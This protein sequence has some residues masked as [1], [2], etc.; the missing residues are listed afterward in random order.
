MLERQAQVALALQHVQARPR[1]GARQELGLGGGAEVE[2][3][4]RE[5][6]AKT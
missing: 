6:G 1:D 3:S 5:M 4:M 2:S